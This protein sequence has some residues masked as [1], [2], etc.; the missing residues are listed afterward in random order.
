M[1]DC[2]FCKLVFEFDEQE[3]GLRGVS[4]KKISSRPERDLLKSVLILKISKLGRLSK[5]R[6][7]C[8]DLN[9]TLHNDRDHQNTLRSG[10]FKQ[11]YNKSKMADGRYLEK[12]KNNHISATPWPICTKFGVVAHIGS[13]ECTNR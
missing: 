12:L 2:M 7:Y 13:T 10:W 5:I 1:I 9:Q 11:T 8:T 4:S 6:K 3:F